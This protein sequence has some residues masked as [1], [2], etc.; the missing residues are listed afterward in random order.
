MI[1]KDGTEDVKREIAIMK[2]ID[3]P[4]IIRLFEVIDD[5]ESDKIFLGISRNNNN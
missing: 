2:K 4:N 5:P 3:H 1:V